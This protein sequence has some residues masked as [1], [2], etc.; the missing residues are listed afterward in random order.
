MPIIGP[1]VTVPKLGPIKYY[2]DHIGSKILH[3]PIIGPVKTQYLTQ[4]LDP[5]WE[6]P[7]LGTYDGNSK[8]TPYKLYKIFGKCTLLPIF[9]L[10]HFQGSKIV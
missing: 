1:D 3:L 2:L 7:Y 6:E 8:L 9:S 4:F 5:L 10:K